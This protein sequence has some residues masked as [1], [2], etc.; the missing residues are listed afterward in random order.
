M[1]CWAVIPAAGT[2]ERFGGTKPKPLAD[3]SGKPVIAHT[4]AVFEACADV[5]G[6]VVVVHCDWLE[7]YKGMIRELK[8][9]KVRA[10]IA[11][12]N[13][14]T[15]SVR[16]GLEAVDRQAQVVMVHDGVRP[17]VD[18]AMIQRALLAVHSTGAAVAGV[19]VK[20]TIKVV[21]RVSQVVC[22]TLDRDLLWEI[23]TP[24][25]FDRVLLERAYRQ[26]GA[27]ASDDAALVERMGIGV[28]VFEGAYTNIKITTPEDM[29]VA[30]AFLV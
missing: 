18:E 24:Q 3:L 22:E 7:D 16:H 25:V 29:L 21:D 28:K 4:L 12:G 1:S 11:G 2:G 17:F 15:Q 23:Q 5:D 9:E 20:P 19:R 6:V 26:G 8:L 10:V 14:R 30:R 13:T 27:G